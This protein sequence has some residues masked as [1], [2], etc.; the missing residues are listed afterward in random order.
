MTGINRLILKCSKLKIR[1]M[2]R[3][4]FNVLRQLVFLLPILWNVPVP[5]QHMYTH[6]PKNSSIRKET[7]SLKS[8]KISESIDDTPRRGK[9]MQ[10]DEKDTLQ[11]WILQFS[12][13]SIM[14]YAPQ[15]RYVAVKKWYD[16]NNDTIIVADAHKKNKIVAKLINKN[17]LKFLNENT[18]LATGN[19]KAKLWDLGKKRNIIFGNIKRAELMTTLNEFVLWDTKGVLKRYNHQGNLLQTTDYIENFVTDGKENLFVQKKSG[20]ISEIQDAIRNNPLYSTENNIERLELS[21]SGVYMVVTEK[22]NIGKGRILTLINTITKES[23]F[24]LGRVPLETDFFKITEIREGKLYLIEAQ[25][26]KK[27]KGIVELWYGNDGALK[28]I[29]TGSTVRKYFLWTSD[30]KKM[31]EIPTDQLTSVSAIGNSRY[32]LAF[33]KDE[34][35]NYTNWIPDLNMHIYDTKT[36]S[37]IKLDI[38]KPQLYGSNKGDWIIYPDV[39]YNWILY[40]LNTQQKRRIGNAKDLKEPVF[41]NNDQHIYFESQNDIWRYDIG[42]ERLQPTEISTG[43]NSQILNKKRISLMSGINF[44]QNKLNA[45]NT[46]LIQADDPTTNETSILLWKNDKIE[47]IISPR[48]STIK[49]LKYNQDMEKFCFIEE[50]LNMSPKVFE[51][52]SK[53]RKKQAVLENSK[54]QMAAGLKQE[55]IHYQDSE[56]IPLRGVLYYPAHFNER[57]KYPMVARIYQIQS[58]EAAAYLSPGYHNP[59]G[60]DPRTLMERGYFVFLPDIVFTRNGTGLS[61][62]DCVNKALDAVLQHQNIDSR[63]IALLGHSHGGYETNF[64]ATHSNRFKTYISGA[65]NSDI[66][67]SYFSY[68]YNFS[69]PFYW[70]YENGQYE[71]NVPFA[72]NKELYFN[73]NPIYNVEKVNSPILLWAGKKDENIAWD[74]VMEFYIGLK[75][76]KKDVIALF[77]PETGHDLDPNSPE[78]KDLYRRVLEW[79]DYFLKNKKNIPWIDKQIRK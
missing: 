54:D 1:L 59:I 50:N 46:L 63:N 29:Q 61:A 36:R 60:F 18:L 23:F 43:K 8:I 26:H 5:A 51:Y 66:V 38:I 20:N 71:M 62:L 28:D 48:K 3:F 76:N 56:G 45:E 27:K 17:Q 72:E 7:D 55:I 64:I 70:Q 53:K 16:Y 39:E 69:S 52:D 14:E 44:F 6:I 74:Q 12:R 35:Q 2:K 79:L 67:R 25:K 31:K 19:K 73:N 4:L 34:L 13:F 33:N 41:N 58:N 9:S 47:T 30:D 11:S 24:P 15:G 40:N 75:R 21:Q 49:N 78:R 65:G 37:F 32:F 42:K 77:Y 68:N 10:T 57:K 22:E